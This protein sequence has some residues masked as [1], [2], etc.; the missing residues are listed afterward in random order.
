MSAGGGA[1]PKIRATEGAIAEGQW[2]RLHPLSP[3]IK[4]WKGVTV[5]LA[6]VLF[7]NTNLFVNTLSSNYAHSLGTGR[8]V[9]IAVGGLLGLVLILGLIS[10]LSW[11]VT[12]FAVTDS[13]VYYRSGILL[14][15]LKQARL[16]RIQ[17]VDIQHP[18]LGRVFGLGT[19]DIEVAGGA[20]SKVA[21]GFLKTQELEDLRAEILARASGVFSDATVAQAGSFAPHHSKAGVPVPGTNAGYG[22]GTPLPPAG[23]SSPSATAGM[24]P[25]RFAPS[26]PE[27]VLYKVPSGRL[28]GSLILTSGVFVGV[29]VLL[30]VLVG[31]GVL[32]TL[33]GAGGLSGVV[34]L[35]PILLAMG[36][37]VWKRFAGEFNFTGAVSPDGI[38][39]RSG[40]LE[41]RS[42][43]IPPNRIHAVRI[44]RPLLWRWV[45]WYRV[46][47]T[48]AGFAVQNQ[49]ETK[50]GFSTDL[51]LPVGTRADAELA[52]WLVVRDLGVPDP[53][54]FM[55]AALDGTGEG[56]GFIPVSTRARILDPLVKKRRAVA[57]TQTCLV[58]RDGWL[59]WDLS[60]IPV[61]RVQSL[62]LAQGPLERRL[63]L[64]DVEAQ[65]VPG[66]TPCRARHLDVS[67]AVALSEGLRERARIRRT[68]EPPERWLSRVQSRLDFEGRTGV[69]GEAGAVLPSGAQSASSMAGGQSRLYSQPGVIPSAVQSPPLMPYPQGGQP[70][71]YPQNGQPMPYPQGG[72][73]AAQAPSGQPALNGLTTPFPSAGQ[74]GPFPQA[75][76]QP[77]I[78]HPAPIPPNGQP[79]PL[80]PN[81]QAGPIPEIP[82]QAS[83]AQPPFAEE[84]S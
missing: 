56:V 78:A 10:Y 58:I 12:R 70:M 77:Q 14:R 39:T 51:L 50:K 24:T 35:L 1:A 17:G 59:S 7:Q 30:A 65:I 28:L 71:P 76:T 73:P 37:I 68:K 82:P 72:Q 46:T 18:L 26:A 54:A 23:A 22:E 84:H 27:R 19:I 43:T 80:P 3:L 34:G 55:S 2:R 52:L 21:F 79:A 48:Q 45:G 6:I 4:A 61:E 13:G 40:L 44:Q 75:T 62:K 20:G 64:A 36:A 60:V 32:T 74:A 57:L 16:E 31:V 5:L 67:A 29:L 81:G 63:S 38:R 9:L 83:S 66:T 15:T 11:R 8:I 69:I 49:E 53:Q 41:T 25:R 33:I 42:Q 47:I